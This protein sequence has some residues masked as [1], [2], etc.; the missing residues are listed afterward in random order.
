VTWTA[1]SRGVRART[2]TWGRPIAGAA[3]DGWRSPGISGVDERLDHCLREGNW[4]AVCVLR[5]GGVS[6]RLASAGVVDTSRACSD[7][8]IRC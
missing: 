2:A 5:A 7:D 4:A 1:Q 6:G 3:N 8:G